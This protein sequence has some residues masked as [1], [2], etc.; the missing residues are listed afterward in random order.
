[1]AT[2]LISLCSRVKTALILTSNFFLLKEIIGYKHFQDLRA[3][4][5]GAKEVFVVESMDGVH[6]S[7]VYSNA[8]W[9][10]GDQ[11]IMG[12]KIFNSLK[13][14]VATIQ[15]NMWFGL[16]FLKLAFGKIKLFGLK[17]T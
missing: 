15:G 1:M 12:E 2:Y 8:V 9:K 14:D 13:T 17:M 7:E 11:I 3:A 5:M 4:V 6:V 16:M 10:R